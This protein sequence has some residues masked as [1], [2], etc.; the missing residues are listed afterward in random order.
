MEAEILTADEVSELRLPRQ[1]DKAELEWSRIPTQLECSV[2]HS[3][4]ARTLNVPPDAHTSGIQ[5]TC[6]DCNGRLGG[7][8]GNHRGRSKKVPQPGMPE[9][10]GLVGALA[11]GLAGVSAVF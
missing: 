6:A 10:P 11:A 4:T 2:C 5:F 3:K 8:S 7:K 9:E 1:W